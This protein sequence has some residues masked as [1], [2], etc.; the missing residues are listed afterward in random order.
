MS[1]LPRSI[2]NRSG[3]WMDETVPII[4]STTLGFSYVTFLMVIFQTLHVGKVDSWYVLTH[5]PL[6][7]ILALFHLSLGQQLNLFWVHKVLYYF[8]F[9][10]LIQVNSARKK[11]LISFFPCWTG[12]SV[13][14]SA[15]YYLWSSVCWWH[16]GRGVEHRSCVPSGNAHHIVWC[17][18]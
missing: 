7:Q 8:S 1:V 15:H 10:L 6:F 4:L 18:E 2:Y 9:I 5:L 14:C 13:G 11:I 16:M 3:E 12:W 17:C